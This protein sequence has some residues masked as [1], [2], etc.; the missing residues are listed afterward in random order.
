MVGVSPAADT[1]VQHGAVRP[2]RGPLM[3]QDV[4]PRPSTFT[5]AVSRLVG[6]VRGLAP[7]LLV[8]GCAS[9]HRSLPIPPEVT[10]AGVADRVLIPP[11]LNVNPTETVVKPG[12]P[13]PASADSLAA[14]GLG[15]GSTFTVPDAIAFGLRYNPRLRSA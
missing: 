8:A 11:D 14:P 12:A 10:E 5:A 6:A 9:W 3:A 13:G 15:V 2:T 7:L 4:L 1:S